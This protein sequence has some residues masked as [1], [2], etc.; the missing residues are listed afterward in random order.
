MVATSIG[1]GVRAGGLTRGIRSMRGALGALT[2]M[3]ALPIAIASEVV[4]PGNSEAVVH[5][6]LALGT[7]LIGLSVFDFATWR[8]LSVLA[9]AAAAALAAVFAAQGL[10]AATQN[11]TLRTFAFSREVGGS[12]ESLTLTVIML[13][14]AATATTLGRGVTTWIGVVSAVAVA[15]LSLWAVVLGPTAGTPEMLRLLFL[16]PIA[17]YLFVSTRRS[18]SG[19]TSVH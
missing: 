9:C 17:W 3:L 13:W 14:F 16:G 19:E 4:A 10:A 18:G 7:L 8:W 5:F 15:G 1:F 2:L 11:D 12:L 6:V